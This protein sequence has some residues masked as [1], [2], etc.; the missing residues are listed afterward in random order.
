MSDIAALAAAVQSYKE[1]LPRFQRREYPG[2]FRK[3]RETYGPLYAAAVRECD[4]D[5]EKLE[6]LADDI[7]DALEAG[8]KA[9]RFWN[10]SAARADQRHMVIVFF[11]PMLM[12]EQ[13]PLCGRLAGMIRQRWADRW[14]KEEYHLTTYEVLRDGFRN[15]IFG[16]DLTGKH[17]NPDRDRK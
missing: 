1:W 5:L 14:P 2:A 9:E 4:G 17:F 12:E 6:Q 10:R 3:Y 16:I 15:V 8:W 13:D 11:S 7:L